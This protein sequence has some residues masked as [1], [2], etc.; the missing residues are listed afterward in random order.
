MPQSS[1]DLALI[2]N[3]VTH[4]LAENQSTLNH[5][6]KFNQD[7]GDNMVQTFQTITEALQQKKGSSTSTALSYA[8]K[9][10]TETGKSSSSKLYAENLNL[11]ALEFKGK[12][13]D[14][15]GAL[16]LLQTLIGGGKAGNG[17]LLGSL[18]GGVLGASQPSKG[19]SQRS[20]SSTQKA[21]STAQKAKSANQKAKSAIQR[22]KSATQKTKSAT[23]KSKTVTPKSK[24]STQK[25]ADA[26][27]LGSGDLLGSILGGLGGGKKT[28][29]ASTGGGGDLLGSI[30]GGLGGG[31][32]TQ[33]AG[34]DL[35]G[36]LLGG[37]TGGGQQ[38]GTQGLMNALMGS[39]GMG[40]TAHRTQSTQIVVDS[41]LKALGGTGKLPAA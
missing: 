36:S 34:G 37:L 15:Q 38:D 21:K 19:S 41:F 18:L 3:S 5:S 11:A 26:G 10:L 8:A 16:Q 25:S 22:K 35:L 14:L 29:E 33:G 17:D 2:F 28:Q 6:D 13:I 12:K 27:S 40:D 31:G 32:Q 30:L 20:K 9:Q 39:S 1:V 24:S 4:S 23:R 7:H